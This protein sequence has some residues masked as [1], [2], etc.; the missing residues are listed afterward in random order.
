M[1]KKID[2]YTNLKPFLECKDYTV[3]SEVYQVMMNEE[4]EMLVTNPV[5]KN[6]EDYYISEAYISHTD[7]KK[8]LFDKIYQTVK[9]Y[10][11]SNKVRLICCFHPWRMGAFWTLR[12]LIQNLSKS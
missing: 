5:P 6:L 4:Y 11:L 12:G 10:S 3:S 2:F 1:T 7:S 8:T 9:K